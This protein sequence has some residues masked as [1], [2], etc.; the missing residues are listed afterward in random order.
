MPTT[1]FRVDAKN[2]FF[3]YPKCSLPK[4]TI[5][6]YLLEQGCEWYVVS[7][8]SHMD[9]TKHLHAL[10]V[11][12]TRKN[13]TSANAFD[14][15]G[16]HPNIQ[17][18]KDVRAVYKYVIKDGDF[19]KNCDFSGKRKY[20]EIVEESDSKD[21]FISGILKDYPRDA[22]LHLEKL[23]YFA[24]WKW[25]EIREE[26]TS[27]YQDFKI[28]NA[29]KGWVDSEMNK[30]TIEQAVEGS[31]PS[32]LGGGPSPLPSYPLLPIGIFLYFTYS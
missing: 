18:A 32:V 3:T 21:A 15:A 13:I 22:C 8:E 6:D 14:V 31:G 11:W 10:G 24:D 29:M 16:F 25:R 23:K 27:A 17:T 7:S 30:V 26:Y 5:R 9:G 12:T 20:G 1:K 2:I 4:E 19:I 28:C